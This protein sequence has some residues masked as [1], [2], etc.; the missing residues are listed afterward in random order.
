MVI[1]TLINSEILVLDQVIEVN[2]RPSKVAEEAFMFGQEPDSTMGSFDPL[3]S[4]IG[5]L[6]ELNVWK[7]QLSEKTIVDMAN[8]LQQKKGNIINWNRKNW[9]MS[10]ILISKHEKSEN[11]CK[12]TS[13][14][15]LSPQK[16]LLKE[17]KSVCEKHGGKLAV[18]QNE[19]EQK[20][21]MEW[22]T[23][24]YQE[25]RDEDNLSND[26]MMWLGAVK[27]NKKWHSLSVSGG[28]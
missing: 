6:S 26:K 3:E 7:Y 22:I 9:E 15:V 16:T 5:D 12:S 19:A 28:L 24:N 25:C 1:G 14:L 11:L 8:C 10:A 4:F 13:K 18:P 20:H 27:I 23:D 2:L 17:A 21:L